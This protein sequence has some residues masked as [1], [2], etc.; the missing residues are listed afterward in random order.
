MARMQRDRWITQRLPER[1]ARELPDHPRLVIERPVSRIP[2]AVLGSRRQKRD[3]KE[4]ETARLTFQ[5]FRAIS[6]VLVPLMLSAAFLAV[7]VP[8]GLSSPTAL[9]VG[10]DAVGPL[11]FIFA[12]VSVVFASALAYAPSETIWALVMV[13]GLSVYAIIAAWSI[14]GP[15]AGAALCVG[16]LTALLLFVR[17]QFYMVLEHTVHVM[18]LFG[19]YHRTLL[20]GFNLLV[21]GEQVLAVVSTAE[22][23]IDAR[24]RAA[25]TADG[26]PVDAAATVMCRIV[27]ERAHLIAAKGPAWSEQV[28]QLLELVL[29]DIV[30]ELRPLGGIDLEFPGTESL[31]VQ[32]KLRLQ[33]LIG[34]WGVLVEWARLHGVQLTT[35]P[36]DSSSHAP[37]GNEISPDMLPDPF[38]AT[39][40]VAVRGVTPGA[41][42]PLPPAMQ[43][44]QPIPEAL[45]AAYDAV[46][47][48][49]I[50]DPQSIARVARAFESAAEDARLAPL[51]PFD[52]LEAA[53]QLRQLMAK[54][55]T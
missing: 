21:P 32:L 10:I 11:F 2:R 17:L 41:M 18:V 55:N 6:P 47:E 45:I 9:A 37:G 12:A 51:L 43:G 7:L 4:R 49:R 39:H 40:D 42:L 14:F 13:A 19:K 53:R 52:A 46:R 54:L 22:V 8:L 15:V 20:P 24:V 33:Q 26:T 44:N 5:G 28:R 50:T 25:V 16:L 34:G 35:P 27:P 23:T 36:G 38:H 3:D 30:H 29:F 48:R 1:I 31:H